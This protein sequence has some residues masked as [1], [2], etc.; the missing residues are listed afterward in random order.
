MLGGLRPITACV[1]AFSETDF[2]ADLP[3][4][5]MPTL[6]IHGVADRT[7][8]IDLTSRVTARTIPGAKLIEYQD[9]AHGLFASHT[10]RLSRDILDFLDS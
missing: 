8:P 3:V 1:R 9:G 10:E 4:F 7:V 6:I 2:R 5:T